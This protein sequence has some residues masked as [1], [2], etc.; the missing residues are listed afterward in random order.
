MLDVL[1]RARFLGNP[2]LRTVPAQLGYRAR[3]L[4]V[5]DLN[6]DPHPFP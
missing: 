4:S 6:P 3:P 1:Q 2:R 5:D